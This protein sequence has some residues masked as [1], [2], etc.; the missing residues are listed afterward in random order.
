[1]RGVTAAQDTPRVSP[2]TVRLDP[3]VGGRLDE[4]RALQGSGGRE[5]KEGRRHAVIEACPR[6]GALLFLFA[7]AKKKRSP[8]L[9]DD[10]DDDDD[11]RSRSPAGRR[12]CTR[13]CRRTR[14]RCTTS[15]S[16]PCDSYLLVLKRQGPYAKRPY[17][18]RCATSRSR[19][20]RSSRSRTRTAPRSTTRS[21]TPQPAW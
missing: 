15:R 14:T 20:A 10:D 5:G 11:P 3:A 4:R 19:R 8:P 18:P 6:T 7:D 12:P 17:E 16:R 9:P 1:M 13:C 2:S 21:R